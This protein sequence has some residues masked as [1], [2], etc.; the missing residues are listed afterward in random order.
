MHAPPLHRVLTFDKYHGKFIIIT[1]KKVV[2]LGHNT[3]Q[4]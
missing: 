2:Q 4:G 1:E 3:G